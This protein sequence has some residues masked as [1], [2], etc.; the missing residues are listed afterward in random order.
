MKIIPFAIGLLCIVGNAC[1]QSP[2]VLPRSSPA[3][4][5]VDP[6]G[7]EA[8]QKAVKAS[9]QELHSFMILRHGKVIAEEWLGNH[10]PEE[11][12]IM[13]SV[14][15][16]FTSTAVG[17]AVAEGRLKLTDKVISFFPND[18]PAT[19]SDNLKQMTV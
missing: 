2:D 6:A 5:N 11:K 12:H 19:L 10:G 15:K 1:S 16:T 17:F 8:Y 7:I 3:A 4:Q 18:L 13:H 9:G 14:S